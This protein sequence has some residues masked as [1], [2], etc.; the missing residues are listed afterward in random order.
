MIH[1]DRN[2]G[3]FVWLDLSKYLPPSTP[4][5]P[6]TQKDKEFAL[7]EKFSE[8]GLFLHP[9]E[10]NGMEPGWFRLVYTNEEELIVEGIRRYGTISCP[11]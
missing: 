11:Y 8:G 4:S 3:C 1:L 9:S 5:Q 7:A 10:E 6:L 2:A